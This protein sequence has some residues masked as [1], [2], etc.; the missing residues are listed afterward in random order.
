[1][2]QH[3]CWVRARH[4]F[5][6]GARSHNGSTSASKMR[7]MT[8]H[9]CGTSDET[10]QP[11]VRMPLQTVPRSSSP[12]R[13]STNGVSIHMKAERMLRPA[14]TTCL[15]NL[16]CWKCISQTRIFNDVPRL[17]CHSTH[18]YRGPSVE[19]NRCDPRILPH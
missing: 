8:D 5:D 18:M 4:T 16:C 15:R 17:L 12:V 6:R 11:T 19:G 2:C 7:C 1:M 13:T 10:Q 3:E 14:R 9:S